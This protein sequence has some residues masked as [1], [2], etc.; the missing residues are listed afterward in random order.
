MNLYN[1]YG[2]FSKRACKIIIELWK[3]GVDL[4]SVTLANGKTFPADITW[5]TTYSTLFGV[6]VQFP[7]GEPIPRWRHI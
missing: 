7:G 2:R 6:E 1:H 4:G 5:R 3:E